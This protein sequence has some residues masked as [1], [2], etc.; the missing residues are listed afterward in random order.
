M[1]RSMNCLKLISMQVSIEIL[2][3]PNFSN[4]M[5]SFKTRENPQQ[6]IQTYEYYELWFRHHQ[7]FK[8]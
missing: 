5:I 1:Y 8:I 3:K 2:T 6:N 7:F 4:E